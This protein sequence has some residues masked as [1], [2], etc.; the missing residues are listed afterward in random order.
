[1]NCGSGV[2]TSVSELLYACY[3]AYW[4]VSVFFLLTVMLAIK[5]L[6]FIAS[7][8]VV[9]L[10]RHCV[11][12]SVDCSSVLIRGCLQCLASLKFSSDGITF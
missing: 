7:A 2:A 3:S 5:C 11:K 9:L 6:R 12:A 8:N 10:Y 1:M 4:S